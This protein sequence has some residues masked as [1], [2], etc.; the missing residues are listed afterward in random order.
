MR[1]A[2]PGRV[3]FERER[4]GPR[5]FDDDGDEQRFHQASYRHTH[6]HTQVTVSSSLLSLAA[7][8]PT[9]VPELLPLR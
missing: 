3:T 9:N 5:V 4:A 6:T 7:N 1:S 2:A 8:Q